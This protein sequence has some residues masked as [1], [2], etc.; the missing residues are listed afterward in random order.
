MISP[1]STSFRLVLGNAIL[2]GSLLGASAADPK[3]TFEQLC[4]VAARHYAAIAFAAYQDS[5]WAAADLREKLQSFT[6]QPTEGKFHTAK[7]AWKKARRPYLQT[8]VFRFYG[9]PIDDE[10][11]LEPLINGWPL[12]EF[13]IDYVKGSPSTGIIHQVEQYPDI[14]PDLLRRHNERAGET[15]ITCGF[16]AIEFLLW[17]QDLSPLGPGTRPLG[18]YLDA[19]QARRRAQYLN[20]CGEL[21]QDHLKT[22]TGDWKPNSPSNYRATFLSHPLRSIWYAVYGMK[23]F[24]GKELAGERLLVAWDTQAQ[25]DEHS[26][27]SDHTL[28]D[29]NHDLQGLANVFYG[30][31]ERA[32]GTALRGVAIRDVLHRLSPERTVQVAATLENAILR[33]KQIPH[34]FDQAI[35]DEGQN[36]GRDTILN[37]ATALEDLADLLAAF[38]QDLIA[39]IRSPHSP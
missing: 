7:Q 15:A 29:L 34:P 31:Y 5:A 36:S 22:L 20:A 10:R 39:K 1:L 9:G 35:L 33:A 23:T 38:E 27:F 4:S 37:T 26:C 24:A 12:D 8:E 19:S 13:Y 16:H 30:R 18:D 3:P 28:I 17:G 11:G 32:N 2:W 21:L 25:E 6:Q 14:T